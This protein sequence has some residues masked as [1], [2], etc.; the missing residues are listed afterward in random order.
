MAKI[1]N[2]CRTANLHDLETGEELAHHEGG[3][4]DD[5]ESDD[6]KAQLDRLDLSSGDYH[7]GGSRI[8]NIL[9]LHCTTEC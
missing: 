1:N 7:G 2:Y 3:G 6:D 8:E 4:A 9:K 5:I